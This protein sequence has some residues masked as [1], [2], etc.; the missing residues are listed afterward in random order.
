VKIWSSL[1]R[2]NF[3]RISVEARLLRYLVPLTRHQFCIAL[4]RSAAFR[5]ISFEGENFMP[6][7][8][9]P[10]DEGFPS[11]VRLER[12]LIAARVAKEEQARLEAQ[13]SAF[14]KQRPR[15]E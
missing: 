6:K 1:L 9:E 8:R 2:E 14:I 4:K 7:S 10:D 11:F 3:G 5:K 13:Y 12:D 15:D